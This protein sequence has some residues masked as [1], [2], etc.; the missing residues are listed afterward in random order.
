MKSY[1][2]MTQSVLDRA[3]M[4]KTVYKRRKS[5]IT[6]V[7]LCVCY[8]VLTVMLAG[9][10]DKQP[11]KDIKLETSTPI[12]QTKPSEVT[13]VETVSPRL[14]LLCAASDSESPEA[15]QTNV[16]LPYKAELRVQNVIGMSEEERQQ[17]LAEENAYVR[18][19]L[20][21]IPDES[22]Y[23]RYCRDNVIVTS[24][25]AGELSIVFDDIETVASAQISVTQNGYIFYPRISGIKYADWNENGLAV[26]VNGD[27][28]RKG[29]AILG[30]DNFVMRWQLSPSVAN[31][32][33]ADPDMDLSQFSDRITITIEYIDGRI[34]KTT[35][36]MFV[37]SNGQIS[38]MLEGTTVVK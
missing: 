22:G 21:V 26:E 31:K 1:E 35:V 30:V 4:L 24:I 34:E 17:V 12:S 13:G 37:D 32:I 16:K 7:V 14:V 25:R 20:G 10:R 6:L 15:M 8:A 28:L 38:A 2:E 3:Q 11:G 18:D 5:S 27:N 29:L 36:M 9:Q 19:F 23:S 33:D